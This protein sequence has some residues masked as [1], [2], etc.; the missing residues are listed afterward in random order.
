LGRVK[1]DRQRQRQ[2]Q[3]PFGDDK[4]KGNSNSNGNGN[5]NGKSNSKCNDNSKGEM[6]GCL[7]SAADDE[8]VRCSGRDDA[9]LVGFAV[10]CGG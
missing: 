3:I 1:E 8:T 5:G 2:K 10:F 7:H 4:Q 9:S 6:R